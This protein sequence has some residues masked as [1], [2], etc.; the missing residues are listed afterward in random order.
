MYAPLRQFVSAPDVINKYIK[1]PWSLFYLIKQEIHLS[2]T[3]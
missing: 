2:S 3:V 1:I